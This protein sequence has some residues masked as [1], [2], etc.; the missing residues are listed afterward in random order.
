MLPCGVI[1]ARYLRPFADPAWF[2]LHVCLQMIGYAL[3]VAGWA[4]GLR[5]GND[6][7]G[8]VYRKHRAIG[9]VLFAIATL[10]VSGNFGSS[11]I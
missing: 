5:L 4:T 8:I 9:I 1:A 11:S 6:S 10:Q 3:G 7:V 2:Y